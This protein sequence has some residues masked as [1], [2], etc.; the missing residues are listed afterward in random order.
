MEKKYNWVRDDIVIDFKVPKI[1]EN[2]M[3]DLEELDKNEDYGYCNYFEGLDNLAKESY[4]QGL[5]TK[6]QWNILIKRYGGY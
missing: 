4:V 5:I 3:L 6:E 1:I 2:L